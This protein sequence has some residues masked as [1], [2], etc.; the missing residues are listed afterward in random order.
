MGLTKKKKRVGAFF[1]TLGMLGATFVASAALRLQPVYAAQLPTE[2][3]KTSY[4]VGESL[5]V[6]QTAELTLEDESTIT[7]NVGT[8]TF[9]DGTVYE[10]GEYSLN[11]AGEYTLT[12][13]AEYNGGKVTATKTFT[14]LNENWSVSSERST[15]Q[16]GDLTLSNNT[17]ITE[18]IQVALADGDAFTYRVPVNLWDVAGKT[19]GVKGVDV[20][21]IFPF[22]KENVKNNAE[23]NIISIKLI[24]CY[25]AS[26]YVEFYVWSKAGT[27]AYLGA[28]ASNQSLG[29]LESY[30]ATSDSR[31]VLYN[32]VNYRFHN[33]SRYNLA[34]QYG[35]SS[36]GGTTTSGFTGL[37]GINFAF[38]PSTNIVRKYNRTADNKA[39][40]ETLVNDLSSEALHGA[41]LF[42][43]FTTGEV[44]FSIEGV[45]YNASAFHFEISSLLGFSGE[46]L[47]Y[48][49][50]IDE[51]EPIVETDV[52]SSYRAVLN[53]AIQLPDD[54][55]V[56]DY[57]YNGDLKTAVYYAYG[58]QQ[59]S[60]VFLKDGG[61]T[62]VQVGTYTAIYSF[63]DTF[64]NTREFKIAYEVSDGAAISYVKPTEFTDFVAGRTYDL[65]MATD[66]NSANG[67]TVCEIVVTNPIGEETTYTADNL[68]FVPSVVGTYKLTYTF[69]D[70]IYHDEFSYEVECT[71]TENAVIFQSEVRMPS[72]F[73]KGATYSLDAYKAYIPSASGLVEVN[74][75]I[76]VAL[77][78]SE[79]YAKVADIS[80]FTVTASET[81]KFKFSYNGKEKIS[82]TYKVVDVQY[83]TNTKTYANYFVG[84]YASTE[85]D[86]NG[87]TY[88]FETEEKTNKTLEFANL[89]SF[90][91]FQL[92]FAIPENQDNFSEIR[93]IL[94]DYQNSKNVNTIVYK[95]G[96]D[97]CTFSVNGSRE[98]KIASGFGSGE[99]L[100]LHNVSYSLAKNT[101]VNNQG[102]EVGCVAFE[103]DLCS[104]KIELVGMDESSKLCISKI[105]NQSFAYIY[106]Q[107]PQFAY[108][109][110][111]GVKIVND[112]ATIYPASVTSVFNPVLTS[113]KMVSVSDPNG[114]FVTSKDGIVLNNVPATREYEIVLATPGSYKVEYSATIATGMSG[115]DATRTE[116][117]SYP[118]NVLDT[119]APTI[120][121]GSLE[122][123]KLAVGETHVIRSYTVADN[124]TETSAITSI[125]LV[126]NEWN[127]LI[128]WNEKTV[129]FDKAGNYSVVFYAMDKDGNSAYVSYSLIV[130]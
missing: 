105:N 20:C 91:N 2:I 110:V 102:V 37:G 50:I 34:S 57:N 84:D 21:Q 113:V 55:K 64:G 30:A 10:S 22:F 66:V 112:S 97:G 73:I 15:A 124:N 89:I 119:Q 44:Y 104:L 16:Y 48:K 31:D 128:A 87:I 127:K 107:A 32:G 38:D 51:D 46:N 59:Q 118:I 122:T 81:L 116:K 24:D 62:P 40:S 88:V 72:Y 109:Q 77:D 26:N 86:Y 29:G 52:P 83:G 103:G 92:T 28:G 36:K 17:E 79:T 74:A 93:I 8:I 27:G 123:V 58:T 129:A 76:S 41:R 13:F 75:E 33:Y 130:E 111:Q 35:V 56:Y 125:V 49:T 85:E 65:P 54:F 115:Y 126:Y 7:A 94:T 61:F 11:Q 101:I 12:Y 78:G 5:I 67:N 90:Q 42:E 96:E 47:Q 45:G 121:V 100:N 117:S 4:L 39:S 70:L 60:A 3:A 6:P 25:D 19:D 98:E 53:K 82:E 1:L 71:D 120:T 68:S 80:N 9:P 108:T 114:N 14:A 106:E 23:V 69:D 43:G 99:A 63:S 18:G 95:N